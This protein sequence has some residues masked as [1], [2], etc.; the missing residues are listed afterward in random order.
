MPV[1]ACFIEAA[2]D[3][4]KYLLAFFSLSV[5]VTSFLAIKSSSISSRAKVGLI[6]L[7]LTSLFFPISIFATNEACGFFCLPCFESPLGL[8]LLALP[9]AMVFSALVG[10]ALIPLY[11]LSFRKSVQISGWL[12]MFTAHQSRHLGIRTPR[13]Y[14]VASQRPF[15]FSFRSF[16]SAIIL[17][18]GM[19]DILAKKELEAVLLHELAHIK[20]RA[21]MFKLSASLMRF[22]PFGV[23]RNFNSEL[24]VEEHRA[25]SFVCKV[26]GTDRHLRSAKAKISGYNMAEFKLRS[27]FE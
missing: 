12:S 8:A 1:D 26:Q 14:A 2:V 15:A 22:S 13:I 11:F 18:V 21:S 4:T 10:F 9:S 17:S 25:D 20:S 19:M 27:N 24:D 6:Y 16:R 3:P 5:A 23:L 7:H